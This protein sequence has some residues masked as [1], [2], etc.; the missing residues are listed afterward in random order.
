MT[1]WTGVTFRRR[2]AEGRGQAVV[3]V[4][5]AADVIAVDEEL[6][7]SI[8]AKCGKGFSIDAML[9]SPKSALFTSWWHQATYDANIMSESKKRKILPMLFFRPFTNTN[10]VAVPASATAVLYG[11]GVSDRGLW[12]THVAFTGYG[13]AGAIGLNVSHSKKN[14]H[15]V[16][17]Q[18]EDVLMCR[19]ADFIAH[20]DPR[21][22]FVP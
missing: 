3:N 21:S 17:I 16:S 22:L 7:F 8:E 15:I 20:V 6:H 2:R 9:A 12:F 1:E 14:K 18:L 5:G 13:S 19:C 11:D 4:E 10:W